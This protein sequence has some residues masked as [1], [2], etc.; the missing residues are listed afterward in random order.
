MASLRSILV[1]EVLQTCRMPAR[2]YHLRYG[3]SSPAADGIAERLFAPGRAAMLFFVGRFESLLAAVL[4]GCA[5]S[6]EE[7]AA[8]PL[9]PWQSRGRFYFSVFAIET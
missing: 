4:S 5:L 8:P 3:L 7:N 2:L 1:R 9:C 6:P